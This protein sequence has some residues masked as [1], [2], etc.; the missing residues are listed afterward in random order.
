M[1]MPN[2]NETHLDNQKILYISKHSPCVQPDSEVQITKLKTSSNILSRTGCLF[3]SSDVSPTYIPQR[4][5]TTS[6]M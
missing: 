2:M 1:Q 3:P 6:T 4:E 5:T